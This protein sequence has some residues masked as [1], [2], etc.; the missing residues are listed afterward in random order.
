[1]PTL[2]TKV[3]LNPDQLNNT[4]AGIVDL[5]REGRITP[6]YAA[7]ELDKQQ[8]YINQ[9]LKR[10]VEHGHVRRVDRGLYELVEAPRGE[11]RETPAER[12]PTDE[13]DS[14]LTDE[15]EAM[16]R[17]RLAGS[18]DKLDARVDAIAMMY[19]RLRRAGDAEKS[20]LLDV[21]DVDA[22]GYASARSVWANAVK[23]KDTLAALPG[24][25][26]PAKGMSTW[27]Y[28]DAE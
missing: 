15:Q 26:A 1:M 12:D 7:G 23:G 21:V 17:D 25:E 3:T 9:R 19:A 8:P 28:A 14:L 27:R 13:P 18:G 4:D 20:D 24:V 10:L 16:L 2:P 6:R 11:P 5:L 22:T